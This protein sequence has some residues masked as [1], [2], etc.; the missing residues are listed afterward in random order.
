MAT[1][2][3]ESGTRGGKGMLPLPP[4]RLSQGC[5]GARGL[6]SALSW[7]GE[8]G[9]HE[10]QHLQPGPGSH[11]LPQPHGA[12]GPA[13][14]LLAPAYSSPMPHA[15]GCRSRPAWHPSPVRPSAAR[16]PC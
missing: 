7:L 10:A 6:G 5:R 9:S 15:V 8:Q 12:Q 13:P 3:G 16:S 11:T 14:A 1:L 4:A 2:M